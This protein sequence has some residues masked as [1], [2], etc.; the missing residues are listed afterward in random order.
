MISPKVVCTWDVGGVGGIP[1]FGLCLGSR[2]AGTYGPE[3][4]LVCT[5]VLVSLLGIFA[6]QLVP[7]LLSG[8]DSFAISCAWRWAGLMFGIAIGCGILQVLGLAPFWGSPLELAP[9][10]ELGCAP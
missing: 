5:T 3:T 8:I 1:W 7:L 10:P 9:V 2:L 6:G 4:F